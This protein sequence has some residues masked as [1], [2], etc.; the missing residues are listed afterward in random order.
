MIIVSVVALL[1]LI[2]LLRKPIGW[3][4]IA[5]FLAVAL[6]AQAPV[7]MRYPARDIGVDTL[8]ARKK[9]QLETASQFQVFHDFQF[10]DRVSESGHE[11]GRFS[12][13]AEIV[14]VPIEQ[15]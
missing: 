13:T 3:V 10:T 5:T 4:F 6:S 1:Y 11:A 2:Y 8:A 12:H 7:E 14:P 15:V 9:A